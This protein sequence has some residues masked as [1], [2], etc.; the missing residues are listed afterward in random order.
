MSIFYR[1]AD[2][3]SKSSEAK[4]DELSE[5]GSPTPYS[6]IYICSGC[7]REVTSVAAQP[8]PPQNHHRHSDDQGK[9]LWRLVVWG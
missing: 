2:L 1:Y 5:P 8:L 6:G 3:L 9:I 7:G 4:F